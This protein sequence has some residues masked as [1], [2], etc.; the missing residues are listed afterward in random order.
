MCVLPFLLS[1][2]F[3]I[4]FKSYISNVCVHVERSLRNTRSQHPFL[5]HLGSQLLVLPDLQCGASI[6]QF[7]D[8][9]VHLY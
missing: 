8:G 7:L 2:K 5:P 6:F 1:E 3:V 9:T 4:T